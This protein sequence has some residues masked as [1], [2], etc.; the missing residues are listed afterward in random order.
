[1]SQQKAQSVADEQLFLSIYMLQSLLRAAFP[2]LFVNILYN[3]TSAH[4]NVTSSDIWN[5]YNWNVI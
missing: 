1:M 5:Y 3:N 2:S 4:F